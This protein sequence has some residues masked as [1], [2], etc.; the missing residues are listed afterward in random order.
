LSGFNVTPSELHQAG[1]TLRGV[2]SELAAG[3]G[4]GAGSV[5]DVG[6]PD[7]AGSIGEFCSTAGRT[8]STLATA[9]E[10]AGS[11]TEQAGS[12]YER[13]EAANAAAAA[14]GIL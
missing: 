10:M 1:A 2:R 6:Y 3:D 7:L 9:V 11:N 4:L 5:G 14:R 8:A 13:A 12:G